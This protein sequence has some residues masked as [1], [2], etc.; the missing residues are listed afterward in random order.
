ME[1]LVRTLT[2]VTMVPYIVN[3]PSS[4]RLQ[5]HNKT[6]SMR[7]EYGIQRKKKSIPFPTKGSCNSHDYTHENICKT[8]QCQNCYENTNYRIELSFNHVL[9]LQL[10]LEHLVL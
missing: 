6:Y 8:H 4:I 1:S 7:S 9:L 5:P 10:T 3:V 2:L